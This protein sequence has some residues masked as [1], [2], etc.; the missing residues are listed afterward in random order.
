MDFNFLLGLIGSLAGVLGALATVWFALISARASARQEARE[1]QRLNEEV[2]GQSPINV[3]AGDRPKGQKGKRS[4]NSP[5][6]APSPGRAP[7]VDQAPAAGQDP[8]A[9][10]TSPAHVGQGRLAPADPASPAGQTSP[11]DQALRAEAPAS[12]RDAV[13]DQLLIND[14]ALGL[15]QARRAFNVSMA[16]SVLGGLVLVLGVALAIFRADTGGQVA[17]AAITSAAG[18]LTSGLSQLFRG[19]ST[20]ALKHLEAQAVELRK[21][22][23]MQTNATTAQRLLEEVTDDDLRSRLQAALILEF[24]GAKLPDLDKPATS[25]LGS[26]NGHAHNVEVAAALNLSPDPRVGF[27]ARSSLPCQVWRFE[28]ATVDH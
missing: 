18:V 8:P 20:K 25:Q 6:G 21:D 15:T 11:L 4:Q 16:F 19:Q 23:R 2:L 13:Y 24:T 5:D 28:P 22:V 7:Q 26:L 17:G 9:D 12:P 3:Y 27:Y 10:H 1:R 14:Y